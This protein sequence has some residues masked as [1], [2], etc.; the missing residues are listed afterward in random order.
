MELLVRI[1]R[2]LRTTETSAS[3]FGRRVARDPKLVQDMRRGREIKSSRLR[4]A[5]EAQLDS[6]R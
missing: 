1:E 2:H 6:V 4:S 5:I 3:Q